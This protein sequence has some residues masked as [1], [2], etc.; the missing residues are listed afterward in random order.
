MRKLTAYDEL[1][2][3]YTLSSIDN[4]FEEEYIKGV[5]NQVRIKLQIFQKE[6]K[7]R[8]I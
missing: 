5:I 1:I 7:Q 6:L 2:V 4:E 8:K 3:R